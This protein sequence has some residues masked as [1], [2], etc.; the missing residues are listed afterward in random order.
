MLSFF[1][2][3]KIAQ[4]LGLS[5]TIVLL[6]GSFFLA[7]LLYFS[8]KEMLLNDRTQGYTQQ[9]KITIDLIDTLNKKFE[10]IAKKDIDLAISS[11]DMDPRD[12]SLVRYQTQIAQ[13]SK[14]NNY[15]IPYNF[16]SSQKQIS[17][18]IIKEIDANPQKPLS[19]LDFIEGD[20][21]FNFYVKDKTS[22]DL[23]VSQYKVTN[24]IKTLKQTISHMKVGKTGYFYIYSVHKEN[25]GVLLLHPKI[26]GKSLWEVKSEDGKLFMQD[27]IKNKEGVVYYDWKNKDEQLSRNK[28]AVF[29]TYAEWGWGIAASAYTDELTESMHTVTKNLILIQLGVATVML[30]V[31]SFL[32]KKLVQ[33]PI[34]DM[35]VHLEKIKN[36]ILPEIEQSESSKNE[37]VTMQSYLAI[38]VNSIKQLIQEAKSS[39]EEVSQGAKSLAGANQELAS[40]TEAQAA[41]VEET[42]AAMTSIS[43]LGSNV[44]QNAEKV[45]SLTKIVQEK[46]AKGV[47]AIKQTVSSMGDIRKS[48][49]TVCDIVSVIEGIASQTNLLALNATIEA[50]RAGEAG[51][52]FA[53]VAQEV[54]S[55][56][57]KS[58]DAAKEISELSKKSISASNEGNEY[59][60]YAQSLIGEISESVEIVKKSVED[61][62]MATTEQASSIEEV[63]KAVSGIDQ[64]TQQN[65]S[66]VEEISMSAVSLTQQSDNMEKTVGKFSIEG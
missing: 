22:S 51:R 52:G 28:F 33:N 27:M 24:E 9:T 39:S 61:L 1:K 4:Q 8:I 18:S 11:K 56:A 25:P 42:T 59:V 38:A 65:A 36:G 20:Y 2:K 60:M 47:E 40:R 7:G 48:A 3:L 54:R 14:E 45:D 41:T 55:L 43:Q 58:R 49:Q 16:K 37:I 50:A 30:L 17:D 10:D 23:V 34:K 29:N 21:Y 64:I 13:I 46:S 53:V 63:V 57:S 44:A 66:M 62:K 6:I 19:R 12:K 15:A 35:S 32:V 26:E 5:I 31:L